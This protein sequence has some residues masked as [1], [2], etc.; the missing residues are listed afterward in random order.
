M[1]LCDK[2]GALGPLYAPT[3]Q[4]KDNAKSGKGFYA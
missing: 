1:K 4:M 3:Q 2:L